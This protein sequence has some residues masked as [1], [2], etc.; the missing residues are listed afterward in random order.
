MRGPK[1]VIIGGVAAGASAAGKA[2]R[3]NPRAKITIFEK[4]PYIS[5]ANC[6]I[7]YYISREVKD[8]GALIIRKPEDFKKKYGVEVHTNTEVIKI[9]RPQKT[10]IVHDLVENKEREVEYD[11]LIIATGGYTFM[12]PIPGLDAFGVFPLRT[13]PD[14]DS[15]E[16]FLNEY[17]PKR[18]A[19]L[20]AG[21]IGIEASDVFNKRGLDV[22]VI[23]MVPQVLPPFDSDMASLVEERMKQSGIKVIIGDAV[24]KIE[25]DNNNMA[26]RVVTKSGRRI[27]VDMIIATLGIRP[28]IKLAKDAGLE[29]GKFAIKVDDYMRTSDPDIYACGDVVQ[30]RDRV[31][32]KLVWSPLAGP[33]NLQGKIAGANAAGDN[34]K[35]LGCLRTS[36]VKFKDLAAG[37]TGLSEREAQNEGYK[38]VSVT[39]KTS[40]NAE[41][42]IDSRPLILKVLAK[43]PSGTIIGAQVV[44]EKGADKRI[45]VLATA[46]WS[47]MT[48]YDLEQLDLA[49]VPPF[50]NS[51]D[52]PNIAGNLLVKKLTSI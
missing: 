16:R 14:L 37:K 52:A 12:P 36:I 6:G 40:S 31:T 2:A 51:L 25:K 33:A 45:D 35:Y 34:L 32:G 48:A 19:V 29:I 39:V 18:I 10:V 26:K 17:K 20:G 41:Y 21:Y 11:K 15:V 9:N 49:Y 7:P 42:Y 13:I 43:H 8:R 3:T 46:I 44:G 28:D 24:D 27:D 47:K 30:V 1:I 4:G 50:S 5:F 38:Y 22:Y 23:E